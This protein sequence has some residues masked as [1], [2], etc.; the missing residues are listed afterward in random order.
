MSKLLK[1]LQVTSVDL[2]KRGANQE[3]H[4]MLAKSA[5]GGEGEMQFEKIGKAIAYALGVKVDDKLN[6]R[7]EV[8]NKAMIE[9]EKS[10]KGDQRLSPEAREKM[11]AKSVEE[12]GKALF[13]LLK[14]KTPKKKVEDEPDPDEDEPDEEEVEDEP[15]EEEDEEE[16]P[17][18]AAAAKKPLRKKGAC[19][20]M[21]QF[22]MEVEK[23]S[24]E[25]QAALAAL[26]AKYG[27]PGT[28][29]HPDVKKAIDEVAA[30]RTELEMQKMRGVAAQYEC[31][32]KSTDELAGKLLELKKSGE[33]NYNAYIALLDEM[34]KSVEESG[35]F[36]ELGSNRSGGLSNDLAAAVAEVQKA[37]P[38]LS[39]AEAVVKAYEQNP[40]L[41]EM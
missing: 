30:L 24:P 27:T 15:V 8:M 19:K 32:G 21:D 16:E 12:Y 2:C 26:K 4:I 1:R 7:L 39:H 41:S 28:E 29:L 25:D 23:M 3:A 22:Q 40:N 17:A 31:I 18:G 36:K 11:L 35:L 5:E 20:K 38:K 37:D 34:K 9:S 13:D 10:I 33:P 14:A 6:E